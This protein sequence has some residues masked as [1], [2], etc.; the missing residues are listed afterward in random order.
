MGKGFN[1]D[2]NRYLFVNIRKKIQYL[3]N[4]KYLIILSK[5][6]TFQVF[7]SLANSKNL[8]LKTTI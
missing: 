8:P 4:V 7:Y 3:A 5:L 2:L 1:D 6:K